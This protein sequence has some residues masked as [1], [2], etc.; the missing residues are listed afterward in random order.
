MAC[1]NHTAAADSEALCSSLSQMFTPAPRLQDDWFPNPA[2]GLERSQRFGGPTHIMKR[3]DLYTSLERSVLQIFKSDLWFRFYVEC[4]PAPCQH[5]ALVLPCRNGRETRA[6]AAASLKLSHF[7]IIPAYINLTGLPFSRPQVETVADV[8]GAMRGMEE[9][10]VSRRFSGL[11]RGNYF[12]GAT[13]VST[14]R[15]KPQTER[16]SLYL[17]K[18][19]FAKC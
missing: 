16:H 1:L 2:A 6:V 9:V 5:A 18:S 4:G 17:N 14:S 8:G 19:V 15:G 12:K 10:R 11:V 7:A 3:A 13:N